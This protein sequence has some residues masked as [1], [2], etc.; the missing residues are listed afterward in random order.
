VSEVSAGHFKK[1]QRLLKKFFYWQ[2]AVQV[3][4]PPYKRRSVLYDALAQEAQDTQGAR[5][6]REGPQETL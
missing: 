2:R 1:F 5:C 6:Y 3:Y 4:G